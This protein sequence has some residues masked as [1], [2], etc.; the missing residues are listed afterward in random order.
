MPPAKLVEQVRADMSALGVADPKVFLPDDNDE[1]AAAAAEMVMIQGE[2][3][4]PLSSDAMFLW[5]RGK[6]MK[7]AD[8]ELE[9]CQGLFDGFQR[10][11]SFTNEVLMPIVRRGGEILLDQAKSLKSGKRSKEKA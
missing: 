5:L 7:L 1:V 3:Q 10:D 4:A 9:R 11:P 6:E 8:S 2:N